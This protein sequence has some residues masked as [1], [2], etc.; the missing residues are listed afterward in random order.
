MIQKR[1][2]F[3]LQAGLKFACVIF[4]YSKLENDLY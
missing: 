3:N 4:Y 1:Y 2:V